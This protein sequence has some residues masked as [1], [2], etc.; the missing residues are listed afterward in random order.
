[1]RTCVAVWVLSG[2]FS[3]LK[4]PVCNTIYPWGNSYTAWHARLHTTPN[5]P[6]P[7]NLQSQ[8]RTGPESLPHSARCAWQGQRHTAHICWWILHT[9]SLVVRFLFW[10]NQNSWNNINPL[11]ESI[12][13]GLKEK[14]FWSS[15]NTHKNVLHCTALAHLCNWG[16]ADTTHGAWISSFSSGLGLS[17]KHKTIF[18][19]K[20]DNR[21]L[22]RAASL[23][24]VLISLLN[25]LLPHKN[26]LLTESLSAHSRKY[27]LSAAPQLGF[28][29]EQDWQVLG[30]LRD[31]SWVILLFLEDHPPSSG[32]SKGTA[33]AEMPH[34][35]SDH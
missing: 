16:R 21:N 12:H 13:Q 17:S 27:L 9:S 24:P 1:M 32:F 23:C 7:P 35:H 10:A 30:P 2:C 34:F 14:G 22:L 20:T 8:Q 31:L 4:L 11:G 3:L 26:H 6:L 19:T 15:P 5:V 33:R 25:T 18:L 28:V 29:M